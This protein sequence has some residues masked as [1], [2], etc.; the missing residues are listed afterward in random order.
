MSQA[1]G[2]Y[3]LPNPS[4]WPIVGSI[5]MFSLLLG[6]MQF[7]N[8]GSTG[9][10]LMAFGGAVIIYMLAGWFGKVARE[11]EG[12]LY[13]AHVGMSF[14]MAMLW[15]IFSEVMFFAGFFGALFYARQLSVPWLAE[16]DLLWPGYAGGWPTAGPEGATPILPDT[17]VTSPDVFSTIGPWGIPFW[18]TVIL[19]SSSITVTI[20]HHALKA[21]ERGK[22]I[23][24]LAITVALGFLFLFFQGFEYFHAY[25]ELGLTLGTGV[26]GATFFMLT[27][28]HGAHVTIGGIIL[29]VIL[30]RCIAGHFSPTNHFAFEAAAWYWHFVDTVWV[31]LFIFVYVL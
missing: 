3:Y 11:S 29:L 26:Y 2:S 8:E 10:W 28:F 27:G 31:G 30:C 5:G 16:T 9:P 21:N 15:F 12:G 19:L 23:I 24:W 20:A 6:F 22:L 18:N 17:P 13:N 25:T 7:L 1:P 4:G 14:R